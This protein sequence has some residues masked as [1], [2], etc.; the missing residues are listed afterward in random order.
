MKAPLSENTDNYSLI[1]PVSNF[2]LNLKEVWEYRELFYFFA[3]RDIKVKYKQTVLGVMWA[4]LQPLVMILIFSLVFTRLINNAG[5]APLDIPYPVFFLSGLMLWNMFSSGLSHAGDSM[6]ANSNI[7]KKIYFPRLIIPMSAIIVTVFDFLITFSLFIILLF[8]YKVTP[9]LSVLFLMPAALILTVVTSLG[10]GT[11]MS[12]LNV[13]YRDFRY[14]LPFMIQILLFISPVIY[15]V[16][17]VKSEWY[18]YL[19]SLNPMTGAIMLSRS[20][21]TGETPDLYM[22]LISVAS[23][24]FWLLLGVYTFRK[25]ESYFADLA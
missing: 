7:I 1:K 19:I 10:I 8:V 20:G 11:F 5:G 23:A 25:T 16:T 13:K 14:V 6:V 2:S 22:L 9:S 18:K 3:W 21:I 24:I 15:P 17:I 4:V 12:A